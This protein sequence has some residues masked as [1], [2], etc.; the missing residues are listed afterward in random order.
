MTIDVLQ[1][2]MQQFANQLIATV[3]SGQAQTSEQIKTISVA[4]EA[5]VN[6]VDEIRNEQQNLQR[7]LDEQQ[8]IIDALRQAVQLQQNPIRQATP[9]LLARLPTPR[10][11]QPEQAPVKAVAKATPKGAPKA[12]AKAPPKAAPK[13][14]PKAAAKRAT[15]A[16]PKARAKPP[17]QVVANPQAPLELAATTEQINLSQLNLPPAPPD[18]PDIRLD[19]LTEEEK[20]YHTVAIGAAKLMQDLFPDRYNEIISRPDYDFRYFTIVGE[21]GTEP[22]STPYYTKGV[23]QKKQTSDS[24]QFTAFLYRDLP[25]ETARR[26]QLR[27]PKRFALLNKNH[28]M[29]DHERNIMLGDA[30][31]LVDVRRVANPSKKITATAAGAILEGIGEVGIPLDDNPEAYPFTRNAVTQAALLRRYPNL[32]GLNIRETAWYT[33]I[34]HDFEFELVEG[35]A[36][37]INT[38][39]FAINRAVARMIHSL[40][41]HQRV[42]SWDILVFYTNG[43]RAEQIKVYSGLR[44][45]I[46]SY[47]HLGLNSI[48]SEFA[49]TLQLE[50]TLTDELELIGSDRPLDDELAAL[51]LDMSRFVI[52]VVN[53]IR[54]GGSNSK[55]ADEWFNQCVV[56]DQASHNYSTCDI[57]WGRI[58]NYKSRH[59]G[60]FFKI[61]FEVLKAQGLVPA[62]SYKALWKAFDEHLKRSTFGCKVS[63]EDALLA[64]EWQGLYLEIYDKEGN[65]LIN[66][67]KIPMSCD[68]SQCI[69]PENKILRLVVYMEHYFQVV[70]FNPTLAIDD[71]AVDP[72]IESKL[73]QCRDHELNPLLCYYDLETVYSCGMGEESVMVPYA[74]SYVLTDDHDKDINSGDVVL[75]KP[76]FQ[77]FNTM[78]AECRTRAAAV[79]GKAGPPPKAKGKEKPKC[80]AISVV[81]IAYNGAKFDHWIILRSLVSMGFKCLT[82]PS[83]KANKLKFMIDNEPGLG[84]IYF[85]VWDP[86]QFLHTSLARAAQ[87]FGLSTSK[88]DYDHL[89]TQDAYGQGRLPQRLKEYPVQEYVRQDVRLLRELSTLF[90]KACGEALGYDPLG[91]PTMA[92]FGWYILKDMHGYTEGGKGD[93]TIDPVPWCEL[94][95]KKNPDE[96]Q[97]YLRTSIIGGRVQG[98]VGVHNFDDPHYMV[99]VVSEYP[100]VMMKNSFPCGVPTVLTEEKDLAKARKLFEEGKEIG[101]YY[102]RYNQAPLITSKGYAYLPLRGETLTW[103]TEEILAAGPQE[104]LLPDV[105][106]RRL[107]SEGCEVEIVLAPEG[108]PHTMSWTKSNNT[109]NEYINLFARIKKE[110]DAKPPEERNMAMREL[111]K[112]GMNAISG[113]AAQKEYNEKTVIYSETEAAKAGKLIEKELSEKRPINIVMLANNFIMLKVPKSRCKHYPAQ[114]SSF[115]YA[116]ARDLLWE[117]IFSRAKALGGDVWYMDTDSAIINKA[118]LQDLRK[119][120]RLVRSKNKQF[121]MWEEETAVSKLVVAAPKFYGLETPEGKVKLRLKG[122]RNND[123][124]LREDQDINDEGQTV[125]VEMLERK[126]AGEVIRIKSFSIY[127]K[128]GRI[129][130]RN[131]VKEV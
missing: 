103:D 63:F 45:Y 78:I 85:E 7:Q 38:F 89:A 60:C 27:N 100:S 71:L 40:V 44:E 99:D 96:M 77:I 9:K 41:K 10:R 81:M 94:L 112:L 46:D 65:L 69:L 43:R 67:T 91:H 16:V 118:Q 126:I 36:E 30:L 1:A 74:L 25:N 18:R 62:R 80:N 110:E 125:D 124:Y 88:G 102:C 32:D 57:G 2:M 13:A 101:I 22:P 61:L 128:D 113:K 34:V 84:R 15:L 59:N 105:S 104:G 116:Y 4:T 72:D 54:Q 35:A 93:G 75:E 64:A 79:L 73:L 117:D 49:M 52:R 50:P 5:I 120:G 108:N 39:R 92:S 109:F 129:M 47:F 86:C 33:S 121:G 122:I 115:I 14:P 90:R 23:S 31:Q 26:N 24:A 21:G 55:R 8:V 17:V 51:V 66:S 12:I 95:P 97:R 58:K 119:R 83:G 131:I 28:H 114:L 42:Q 87:A 76:G 11:A 82:P 98:I 123:K 53:P 37:S 70:Q 19:N 130:Y 127:R 56:G 107:I 3:N 29:T 48:A 111:G 20:A 6:S 106:M 68:A